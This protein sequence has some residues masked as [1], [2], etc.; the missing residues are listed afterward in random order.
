MSGVRMTQA[1]DQTGDHAL[2][3]VGDQGTAQILRRKIAV[4]S[5]AAPGPDSAARA[6]RVGLARAARDEMDLLLETNSLRDER[7]S[8][9]ELL[10]LPPD[11]AFCAVLEGPSNGL[12]LLVLSPEMLGAIIEMQTIGEV[13]ANPPLARRP[14]RTD[15]AMSVRL[16][17][18]ALTALESALATSPDLTWTA[19]FRYA[20][21]LEDPRPLGLLLEDIPYRVLRLDLDIADG[22]RRGQVILALPAEGRGP[23]PAS[24]PRAG[25]ETAQLAQDWAKALQETVGISEVVI[26]GQLARIRLPLSQAMELSVGMVLPLGPARLGAVALVGAE[27]K[28]VGQG[29]LGQHRGLRAIRLALVSGQGTGQQDRVNPTLAAPA[30]RAEVAPA[31]LDEAL[32]EPSGTPNTTDTPLHRI[33]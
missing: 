7:I 5:S 26:E 18:L 10:E 6:W 14:T 33:A 20:S 30:Q 31:A 27:G 28:Q 24:R 16:I 32:A 13:S 21:F 1:G 29:R 4:T 19:G 17:D 2:G 22:R 15:A 25:V 9:A 3:A 12:G 11:K 23:K 8:L